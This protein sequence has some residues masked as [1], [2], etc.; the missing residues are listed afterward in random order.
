[1]TSL[2]SMVRRCN[3]PSYHVLRCHGRD[4]MSQITPLERPLVMFSLSLSH[5]PSLILGGG[6]GGGFELRVTVRRSSPSNIS[7]IFSSVAAALV[8]DH[9]PLAG[10][11][12]FLA[13]FS[14]N[15]K[16]L[17]W[18]VLAV[19]FPA[20]FISRL[21]FFP[22][23]DV[24]YT[25]SLSRSRWG[26]TVVGTETGLEIRCMCACMCARIRA[27]IPPILVTSCRVCYTLLRCERIALFKYHIRSL[28]MDVRSGCV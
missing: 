15:P 23:N 16:P 17:F 25:F 11:I 6:G 13:I 21:S 26:L 5:T 10:F 3:W 27:E 28:E 9:G 4:T 22:L 2:P 8:A 7:L 18:C 1:M 12:G 24:R 19:H 14:S 20:G